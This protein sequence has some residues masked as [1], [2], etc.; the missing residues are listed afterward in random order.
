VDKEQ[1]NRQEDIKAGRV[2][3]MC[4]SSKDERIKDMRRQYRQLEKEL[5]T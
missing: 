1:A 4:L 2:L 3:D 5:T